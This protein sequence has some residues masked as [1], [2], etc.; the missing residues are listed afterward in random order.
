VVS[1]KLLIMYITYSASAFC[2]YSDDVAHKWYFW[3]AYISRYS[4]LCSPQH[5]SSAE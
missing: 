1:G 2:I 5:R 4:L 3:L